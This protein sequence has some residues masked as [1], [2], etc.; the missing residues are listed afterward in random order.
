MSSSIGALGEA[1]L[2]ARLRDRA[3]PPPPF[4]TVG[5]GDD[6][7]VLAPERGMH[8]VVTM[9]SLVEGVHFQRAW[10]A[11]RDLGHKALAVNLSDL[12]AMGASPRAALLSLALPE[13]LPVAD[14]DALID[15]FVALAQASG[16]PLVGGNLTRSPGP[17]MIDVTAMGVVRPR[18]LL[19]RDGARSGHDLYVTGALGAAATGLAMLAA[20]RD[21]LSLDE[22][23]AACVARYECPEARTRCGRL[24]G[25]T[26]SAAAAIDVSDGLADAVAR[27]ADAGA[28]GVIIDAD[29]V[30]VHA[31]ARDWAAR[32]GQDPLVLA[33]TGGEDYEL[34]FAVS[35]R[36]RH[37]FLA[38]LRRCPDLPITR[39]GR[40][41]AEPGHWIER[42]GTR[43][44]LPH[45]FAH[46]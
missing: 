14:F 15:G 24:V 7:A 9:D 12:A 42:A 18:R 3:G 2:V 29:A 1:A 36:Q 31:G 30:P 4:V 26:G 19:R 20:G 27:L 41:V 46:F 44:P 5:I 22:G 23:A 28:T 17:M 34:A 6:A 33:L 45:G 11:P 25:R 13:S 37:K 38:A 21:R 10:T 39:V 8:T 40:F 43:T 32:S 16:T 35:P